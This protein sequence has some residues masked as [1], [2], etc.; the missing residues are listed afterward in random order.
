MNTIIKKILW[1]IGGTVAAGGL[2]AGG[3]GF[4][5][6]PVAKNAP[7]KSEQ[8]N[9]PFSSQ[10]ENGANY[11]R[12]P[13]MIT[14]SQGTVVAAMDA[15]F[16]GTHDSPNNIDT[17][18]CTST[19]SGANWSDLTMP[20][21][22]TDQTDNR[23]LFKP[24][25]Q[26]KSYASA[27][28]IDPSLLEDSAS[29]RIFMLVD[30]FPYQTGAVEAKQGNGYT[31]IDGMQCLTLRKKGSKTYDYTVRGDR[32]IYDKAGNKTEYSLNSNFEI[33]E[34]GQPLMVK[35][36]KSIHWY[37]LSLPVST[38]N[39]VPMNIMY[40]SALFQ[41]Y[42]TSYL[43]LKYS[44]DQG[45][46]WSDPICLNPSVKDSDAGFLGVCPGR[47]IQINNGDYKG[48]LIFPVYEIDWA[49][50][51]QA[52][53]I[54]YSDD[55]GTTWQKGTTISLNDTVGNMSETQLIQYPDGTLQAFSRTQKAGCVGSAYSSDGGMTWS[56]GMLVEEL[57]LTNG[58]GCQ[59]SAINYEGEIDGYPAVLLSAPAG[60]GRKNGFI[61]VG[62]IEPAAHGAY[63][64][65]W[66]YQTE[67][68]DADSYFAYSCLT[69]LPDGNIGLLY[70]QA[71]TPQTVD[72]T[73][74]KSFTVEML[75]AAPMGV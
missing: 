48:R 64:I 3:L 62:L 8:G 46:T 57:P 33:L 35:Q 40:Q 2:I 45:L 32:F 37:N 67:I 70:E 13:A 74:F 7:F 69:Q 72:T 50:D 51:T 54:I 11:Y 24:N 56:D 6:T 1:S 42:S 9:R 61:Y 30:A 14:T 10:A 75:T 66:A 55:H 27:S 60:E 73:Y 16:G 25:G 18:V 63:Q 22:F 4:V 36:K 68:T 29:G 49:K 17:A 53:S 20:F 21:H 47:G 39:H 41:P 71:N 26:L 44:D 15:R 59:I 34:K 19:D 31:E 65:R 28:F 38:K 12:I 5:I 58:S 23:Q 43:Y 52:F